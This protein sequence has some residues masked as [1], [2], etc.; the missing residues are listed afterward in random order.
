MLELVERPLSDITR[1]MEEL[2]ADVQEVR[3]VIFEPYRSIFAVKDKIKNLFREGELITDM[4]GGESFKVLHTPDDYQDMDQVKWLLVKSLY[5][6]TGIK[7]VGTNPSEGLRYQLKRVVNE[8]GEYNYNRYSVVP[9]I[10]RA[11]L[12][13]SGLNAIDNVNLFKAIEERP[14]HYLANI[15]KRLFNPF[16]PT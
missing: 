9:E 2:Q 16:K 12:I 7:A 4:P 11:L 3:S 13:L 6:I 15:K 5:A 14:K 1:R 8:D 10:K